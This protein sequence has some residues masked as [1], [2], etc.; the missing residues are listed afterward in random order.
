MTVRF[1]VD[2]MNVI[3]S[4]PDAWWRDRPA[5]RMSLVGLLGP[6]ANEEDEVTVVFDGTPVPGEE[7]AASEAG[8]S[9][10]FA[11]GS[12]GAADRVIVRLVE[13]MRGEEV[14]VV[15]SDEELI[16]LVSALGAAVERSGAFRHRI[17]S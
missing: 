9:A 14:T 16:G 2:G 3:G 8:V 11:T 17:T 10:I 4:R 12:R 1:L 7:E 6:L 15:T 13:T 5:S